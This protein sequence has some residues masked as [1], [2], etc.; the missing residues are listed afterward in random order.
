MKF[1][2]WIVQPFLFNCGSEK[3]VAMDCD[4][5]DEILHL[6]SDDTIKPIHASKN[7]LMWLDPQFCAKYPKL[8]KVAEHTLLPFPTT[9]L[10]ECAFRAVTDILM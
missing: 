4:L 10:V 5:V 1:P 7:Q 9:Y 8:A 2:S 3:G 6:Q